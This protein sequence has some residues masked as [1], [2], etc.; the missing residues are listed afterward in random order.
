LIQADKEELV[1]RMR[2][3]VE[4][5]LG[6]VM[7]AVN[8]ARDGHL[9]DDSEKPV[10]DVL[11]E[12]KR[13]VYQEALQ[14]RLDETEAAFSPSAQR[15]GAAPGKQGAGALLA[16]DAAGA[17]GDPAAAVLRPGRPR[18]SSRPGGGRG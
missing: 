17:G 9:I 5:C 4:E 1:R 13:R 14:T 8:G 16:A 7:A 6:K 3:G 11:N 15:G 12:F 10:N 18:Q 2:A